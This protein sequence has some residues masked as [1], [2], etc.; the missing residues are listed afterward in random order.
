M[1]RTEVRS[2]QGDSHLGHVFPDGPPDRGGLR[3]CEG[4]ST[5][6]LVSNRPD[7]SCDRGEVVIR[8]GDSAKR[9]HGA[10]MLLWLRHSSLDGISDTLKAPIAPKPR[11]KGEIS[12]NWCA[13]TASTMT[14]GARGPGNLAVKDLL[15]KRDQVARCSWGYGQTG[16][17]VN[18]LW[19]KGIRRSFG[20]DSRSGCGLDPCHLR[21][22]DV[23]YSPDPTPLVVG[24]VK[25]AVRPDCHA[26]GAV[27][28]PSRILE[29]AGETVGEDYVV[30]GS[31]AIGQRLEDDVVASLRSWCAIPRAMEGDEGASL[32]SLRKLR[33]IVDLEIVGRPVRWKRRDG[34]IEFCAVIGFLAAVA[35]IFR[36]QH[37]LLLG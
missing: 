31:F 28:C 25:R 36:R 20:F 21:V 10:C 32:V 19:R 22:A 24:D 6:L 5:L 3:Y 29:R 16:I 4:P 11:A 18:A 37:E 30:T 12:P 23:G 2:T 1:I 13:H 9:R 34:R 17:R 35:A 7:I 26:G 27:R 33:G 14:S 15:A 8:Q